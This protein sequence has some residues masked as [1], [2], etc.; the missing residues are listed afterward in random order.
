MTPIS[1][2]SKG[3]PGEVRSQIQAHTAKTRTWPRFE[4]RVNHNDLVTSCP[5][6]TPRGSEQLPEQLFATESE[7]P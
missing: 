2:M 1:H 4:L 5:Y 6:L 3:R 7:K